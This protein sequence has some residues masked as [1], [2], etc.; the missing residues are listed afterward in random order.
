MAIFAKTKRASQRETRQEMQ[1]TVGGAQQDGQLLDFVPNTTS[2]MDEFGRDESG[3]SDSAGAT[4]SAAAV[5]QTAERATPHVEASESDPEII[6]PDAIELMIDTDDAP[7]FGILDAIQ[8][9]RSLPTTSNV[10]LVARV[11]RVTLSAVNVSIEDIIQ[12]ALRK[13]QSIQETIAALQ[14]QAADL[15]KQLCAKRGEIAAQ[16][17]DLKESE[18]IRERLHMADKHSGHDHRSRQSN[19]PPPRPANITTSAWTLA[20]KSHLPDVEARE[21]A[22]GTAALGTLPA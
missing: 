1:P 9:M 22:L 19:V 5:V 21:I 13:E 15:E 8:L 18:T 11:V 12:G 16:G 7:A 6:E 17:A 14:G 2:P 20:P 3:P 10:E 4:Q